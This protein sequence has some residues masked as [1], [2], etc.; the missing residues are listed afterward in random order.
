MSPMTKSDSP[1]LGIEVLWSHVKKILY[2]TMYRPQ[3]FSIRWQH[4]EKGESTCKFCLPP[5]NDLVSPFIFLFIYWPFSLRS[6]H[7]VY[8]LCHCIYNFCL[9]L[10]SFFFQLIIVATLRKNISLPP[11]DLSLSD[12]ILILPLFSRFIQTP[13]MYYWWLSTYCEPCEI[14]VVYCLLRFTDV[15]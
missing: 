6:G 11:V 2:W 13:E 4:R 9:Y 7:S 5:K 10:Y 15:N 1:D 14:C 3:L 12:G 8:F